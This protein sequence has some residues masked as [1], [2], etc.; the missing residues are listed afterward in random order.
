MHGRSKP[1]A[2]IGFP[3]P[4]LRLMRIRCC[5]AASGTGGKGFTPDAARQRLYIQVDGAKTVLPGCPK[6]RMALRLQYFY[7]AFCSIHAD[8]L[9]IFDPSGCTFH[10]DN[11]R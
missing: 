6:I 1:M 3:L 10:S 5:L 8:S 7:V 2:S 9:P 11:C 4:M